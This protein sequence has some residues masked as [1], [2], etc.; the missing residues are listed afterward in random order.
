MLEITREVG[1]CN[2]LPGLGEALFDGGELVSG[3]RAFMIVV[4]SRVFVRIFHKAR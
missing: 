4:C 2:I 1:G 3:V